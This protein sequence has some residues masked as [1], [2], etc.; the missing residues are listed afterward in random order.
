[1]SKIP[2]PS[3]SGQ[4]TPWSVDV[5]VLIIFFIRDEVLKE[6][7]EAVRKA[8][9]RRLLLW[10]DGARANRPDD[11]VKIQKCREIVENIDW[12]CEVYK[13]YQTCNWGCDPSTFY[14]HK[15]AFSIVDKCIVLE[16]DCVP[17]Q[18]FFPYCKELLDRYENDT[19]INRI[20]GMCQVDVFDGYPY[21][22]T[23]ASFGSVWGWATWKRVADL[24][25]EH[26]SYLD[27]PYLM[28]LYL[29]R[30]GEKG[31]KAYLEL[32]KQFKHEGIAHWE[33]IQT[34]A[35][36]LNSQIC[37]IPTTNL[38]HNIGIGEDSTHSKTSESSVTKK[39]RDLFYR[40]SKE[41]NFPLRHPQYVMLNRLYESKYQKMARPDLESYILRIKRWLGKLGK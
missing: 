25:D 3:Y 17:S 7:F 19:R 41:M 16:D 10:Q 36:V 15:W 2:P 28:N 20:C 39:H 21:D 22:Y 13:N 34:F 11:S 18:S 38:I 6:T 37:I 23:F 35:R 8:R 4:T 12:D 1:M 29:A 31:D 32:T 26:Y 5:N 9:P 27:D 30:K 33:Q 24:W 40:E 14:S